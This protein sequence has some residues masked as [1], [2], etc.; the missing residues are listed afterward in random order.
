MSAPCSDG[1]RQRSFA[2]HLGEAGSVAG[3]RRARRRPRH[4]ARSRASTGSAIWVSWICTSHRDA[5]RGTRSTCRTP[6]DQLD[7][8]PTPDPTR[9]A[10]SPATYRLCC[11]CTVRGPRNL[12][13][14]DSGCQIAL[15]LSATC[16]VDLSVGQRLP[17]I[18]QRP[19][20]RNVWTWRACCDWT[21]SP[22]ARGSDDAW[23]SGIR[24][25]ARA[26]VNSLAATRCG[27][28]HGSRQCPVAR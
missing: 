26:P 22:Q 27:S 3:I 7:R 16:S 1:D 12:C 2:E 6:E 20:G 15:E 24:S 10:D 25:S 14:P 28:G 4:R 8:D 11:R 18:P 19:L 23:S 5:R 17:T 13:T 21:G 9:D